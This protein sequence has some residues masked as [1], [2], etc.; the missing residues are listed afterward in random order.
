MT[1]FSRYRQNK[2]V[3]KFSADSKFAFV[4]YAYFTVLFCWIGHY[5]ANYYVNI[6]NRKFDRLFCQTNEFARNTLHTNIMYLKASADAKIWT[7]FGE[8]WGCGPWNEPSFRSLPS[9][10][11]SPPIVV[12]LWWRVS[13]PHCSP[14]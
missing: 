11:L 1:Y 6:I 3:S 13:L 5:V 2:L 7:F 10:L 4:S 8:N 14:Y 12:L 9:V